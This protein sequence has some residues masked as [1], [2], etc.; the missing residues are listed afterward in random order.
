VPSW[1]QQANARLD[2][3]VVAA[4]G[5]PAALSD[6]QMLSRLLDLNLAN[7][8]ASASTEDFG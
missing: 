5:W 6:D 3:A 1:L 4:Y 8:G 7:S 2:A